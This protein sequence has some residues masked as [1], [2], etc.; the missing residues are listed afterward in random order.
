MLGRGRYHG[1]YAGLGEGG[2]N[3]RFTRGPGLLSLPGPAD[4]TVQGAPIAGLRE[5][6]LLHI[7]W[8]AMDE[9]ATLD[10]DD[11]IVLLDNPVHDADDLIEDEL[12]ESDVQTEEVV[13]LDLLRLD[14]G[15]LEFA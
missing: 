10:E 13:L 6:R 2:A 15:D 9:H 11:D 1:D 5:A 3:V 12:D 7:T 14:G 4:P 8:S